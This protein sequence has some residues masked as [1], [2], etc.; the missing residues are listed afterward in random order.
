MANASGPSIVYMVLEDFRG[1]SMSAL[2]GK[3]STPGRPCAS[4]P[5]LD[6]LAREGVLFENAFAQSPICNPSRTSTM[7][8]RYPTT[9]GVMHNDA[10]MGK[11][12][13]NL[14]QLLQR[15]KRGRIITSSPYSKV[16]HLPA[17][18]VTNRHQPWERS[19]WNASRWNLVPAETSKWLSSSGPPK[20][21]FRGPGYGHV[22]QDVY[23]HM[24][25]KRTIAILAALLAQP[26]PFF[27]GCGIS[28]THTPL[29]PPM[30]FVQ[31]ID[32][33]SIELPP[34]HPAHGP[35]LA[36]KDGF[37]NATLTPTQQRQYIATYLAAAEYVDAQ[38][39][40]VLDLLHRAEQ[41]AADSGGGLR[42][43]QTAVLVHA[44][45]GFHLGE[46]GRWSKYTMYEE[47]VHVPLILKVPGGLAG[48]RRPQLVELVDVLPTLLTMWGVPTSERPTALD[49][50]SLL[51]LAGF[52]EAADGAS[53]WPKAGGD[54]SAVPPSYPLRSLARSAM[55]HPIRL[56]TAGSVP[57]ARWVCAELHYLRSDSAA[58]TTYLHNGLVVNTTL[59]DLASDP[60]EQRNLLLEEQSS[61]A[62]S[63]LRMWARLVAAE[64][65]TWARDQVHARD[66]A[67]V[68]E[69]EVCSEFPVQRQRRLR[70]RGHGRRFR[71]LRREL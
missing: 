18:D 26:K 51:P 59:F 45:H 7:T 35:P 30:S 53:Y 34:S 27:F 28:G 33:A 17:A 64:R 42:P 11:P 6:R 1:L 41:A 31:R 15:A 23:H 44:D 40:A 54:A 13:A 56:E 55:R 16:F 67:G 2:C 71:Y 57:D 20:R 46:H 61:W 3:K 21:I 50:R 12:L 65:E 36:R 66:A 37:Q 69:G 58:F 52:R 70:A 68:R 60:L 10:G 62:Y 8:G 39:G 25:F 19:W 4:T 5:H 43:R 38:V 63:T 14:P 29:V 47:A 32:A 9:T 22:T 24:A 48:T 49:G